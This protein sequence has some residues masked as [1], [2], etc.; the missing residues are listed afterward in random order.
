MGKRINITITDTY[1]HSDW[2]PIITFSCLC[3]GDIKM[4]TGYG[5]P[6]S[7]GCGSCGRQWRLDLRAEQMVG[8]KPPPKKK[9]AKKRRIAKG[10]GKGWVKA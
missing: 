10:D 8:P 4:A 7:G 2:G 5:G 3:G 9:A 6:D 1:H